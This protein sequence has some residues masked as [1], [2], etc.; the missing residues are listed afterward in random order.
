MRT[1]PTHK[2][3]AMRDS[4]VPEKPPKR[5]AQTKVKPLQINFSLPRLTG[6][7]SQPSTTTSSSALRLKKAPS[8]ARMLTAFSSTPHHS[9]QLSKSS[10]KSML[11]KSKF[12]SETLPYYDSFALEEYRKQ[13]IRR[14]RG[15]VISRFPCWYIDSWQ[16]DELADKK[17]SRLPSFADTRE[18]DRNKWER[19]LQEKVNQCK[20]AF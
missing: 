11:S 15:P 1:S 18:M 5:P 13:E 14:A 9:R 3:A 16:E 12:D 20:L 8:E 2:F 17:S 10:T 7:P 6:V 19:S 4:P